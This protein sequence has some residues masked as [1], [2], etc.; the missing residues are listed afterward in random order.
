MSYVRILFTRSREGRSKNGSMCGFF[1][2]T[3][4]YPSTQLFLN[5]NHLHLLNK[6]V[7]QP[8][9]NLELSCYLLI[10][11]LL[12]LDLVCS[13]TVH[14]WHIVIPWTH[15][16][17]K[18]IDYC[19]GRFLAHKLFQGDFITSGSFPQI[20]E[21]DG[22]KMLGHSFRGKSNKQGFCTNAE[23]QIMDEGIE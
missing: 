2:R 12:H 19:I 15:L 5:P 16:Q 4:S 13:F 21:Q 11:R 9:S 1:S 20:F 6:Q 7:K 17:N 8:T 3:I 22:V 18:L 14:L 10:V 23:G